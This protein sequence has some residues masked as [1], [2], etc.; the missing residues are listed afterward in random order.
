MGEAK[1]RGTFEQRKAKAKTKKKMPA[2]EKRKVLR[3]RIATKSWTYLLMA[4]LLDGVN[5]IRG[6]RC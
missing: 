2:F 3:D 1:K 5:P 4:G 6:R